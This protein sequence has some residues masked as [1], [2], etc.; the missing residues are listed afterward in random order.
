MS[1]KNNWAEDFMTISTVAVPML[2]IL[3]SVFAPRQ[4]ATEDQKDTLMTAGITA[5]VTGGFK[6][7]GGKKTEITQEVKN[8]E[9]NVAPSSD[10]YYQYNPPA[11]RG[12]VPNGNYATYQPQHLS[13]IEPDDASFIDS[14][15]P[16]AS[17]PYRVVSPDE[18]DD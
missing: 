15:E 1:N 16:I 14:R 9:L 12:G 2:L 10:N 6:G 17:S 4:L 7:L 5:L 18:L 11:H 3:L 8:Q 13:Q